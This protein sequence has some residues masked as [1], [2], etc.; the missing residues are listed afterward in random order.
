MTPSQLLE[1]AR[2]ATPGNWHAH[3]TNR[4]SPEVYTDGAPPNT[5]NPL[6]AGK[7]L[8]KRDAAYIAALSPSRM[9]PLLEWVLE[10]EA[11]LARIRDLEPEP[12][13][14]EPDDWSEQIAACPECQRYRDHPIQNGIC[15]T[16]RQPIWA[17]ERHAE[18]EEKRVGWRAK[19]IARDLL[20]KLSTLETAP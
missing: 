14:G 8:R 12:F 18:R 16:H 1:L 6:I 2:G 5:P 15:D 10:A 17:R 4:R 11:T 13:N 7:V 20:A 3:I 9:V 19:V